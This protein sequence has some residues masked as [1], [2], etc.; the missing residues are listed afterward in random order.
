MLVARRMSKSLVEL[1]LP[2]TFAAGKL[3]EI[4]G[5]IRVSTG[6]NLADLKN[7]VDIIV[8]EVERVVMRLQKTQ[9][10]ILRSEKFAAI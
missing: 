3:S 10:E 5:P 8:V 4:V 9:E 1:N 6:V 7:I 2:L